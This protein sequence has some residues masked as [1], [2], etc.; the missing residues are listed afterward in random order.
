MVYCAERKWPVDPELVINVTC[1]TPVDH[2]RS[3]LSVWISWQLPPSIDNSQWNSIIE[4]VND[5]STHLDY[6]AE[7]DTDHKRLV[8]PTN[9][10]FDIRVRP[11]SLD[12]RLSSL[13]VE[14]FYLQCAP[15]HHLLLGYDVSDTRDES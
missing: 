2:Q 13:C 4:V 9:Q 10:L 6:I 12:F 5:L 7:T 1:V 8:L 3:K 14:M 11:S 15:V